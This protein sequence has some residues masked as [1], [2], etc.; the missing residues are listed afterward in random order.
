MAQTVQYEPTE[1]I[2]T[3]SALKPAE[4]FPMLIL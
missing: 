1:K 2:L 4:L 3:P